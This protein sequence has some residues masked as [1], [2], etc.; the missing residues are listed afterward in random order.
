MST[1]VA[2]K[3]DNKLF[4]GLTITLGAS[5]LFPEYIAPFF[6]FALYI[7]FIIH[8]KKTNRNAR[9]GNLIKVFFAYTFY[10]LASSIWSDTHLYSG[11]LAMLWMG[12]MLGGI[13]IANIITSEH[14]LKDAITAVNISAGIIGL[15]SI[16]EFATYNLDKHTDWFNFVFPNPLFY[17]INDYI[18]DLLPFSIINKKYASRSSAT[19]DNPLILATYLV[20]TTPFCAFGSVYFKE[21]KHRKISRVCLVLAFVGIVGTSSRSAF[22]AIAAA[23]VLMIFSS[24]RL[25]K[26][27]LPVVGVLA[28]GIP[29]GLLVR[30]KNLSISDF[31]DSDSKRIDIWKSCIKMFLQKPILGLGAGTENVYAGL[32]N[33]YGIDRSH[34][35]NTYLELL[36]EGGI[37]GGIFVVAMGYMVLKSIVR[38]FK[39]NGG[40]YRY[41]GVLYLASFLAFG[42]M[43]MTEFTIQSAKELM[44]MFFLIGFIEAT[45]RLVDGTTQPAMDEII[46]EKVGEV[47]DHKD[48]DDELIIHI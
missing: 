20:M 14:K 36:V 39:G 23:I 8:F 42:L 30:Y 31:F 1:L 17:S 38:I 2:S 40:I 13:L 18:F 3:I 24:K 28:V 12:C 10:M 25:M 41:Y 19:F 9:L 43:S 27:L 6:V 33:T 32:L 16:L 7:Y 26:K 21:S 37:V 5:M 4:F 44:L 48:D 35:H 22:I 45:V 47:D 15:I 11:A 29:V 34:A 46:Y